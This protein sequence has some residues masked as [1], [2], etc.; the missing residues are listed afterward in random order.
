MKLPSSDSKHSP[1]ADARERGSRASALA[2]DVDEVTAPHGIRASKP[3][4]PDGIQRLVDF[5]ADIRDALTALT[6]L[7]RGRGE[8]AYQQRVAKELATFFEGPFRWHDLD[9]GTSL[10]PRLV[11]MKAQSGLDGLMRQLT[12]S[13]DVMDQRLATLI[14]HLRAIA[15]GAPRDAILL[16]LTTRDLSSHLGRHLAIEEEIVFPLARRCLSEEAI[17]SIGEE[18]EARDATRAHKAGAGGKRA[19]FLSG[20]RR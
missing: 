20:K 6:D 12:R 2:A 18:F 9:E 17:R 4:A 14:P 3:A 19:V 1:G 8:P 5:H 11:R 13:Q 10:F 7:T 16:R 15:G